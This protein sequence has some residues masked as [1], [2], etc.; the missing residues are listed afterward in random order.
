M[1]V[2][3]FSL[4]YRQEKEKLLTPTLTL[5]SNNLPDFLIVDD[6]AAVDEEDGVVRDEW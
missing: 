3:V 2:L 4:D 5:D 1:R 6:H